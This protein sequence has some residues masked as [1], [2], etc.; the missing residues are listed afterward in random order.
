MTL[1]EIETNE[2][3]NDRTV[4]SSNPTDSHSSSRYSTAT[5]TPY[6]SLERRS[7]RQT[8]TTTT[9]TGAVQSVSAVVRH[10]DDC[11]VTV[12]KPAFVVNSVN[13]LGFGRQLRD[14]ALNSNIVSTEMIEDSESE[15]EWPS[16][17]AEDDD[18]DD[19]Q[20][21]EQ[22]LSSDSLLIGFN[23]VIILVKELS[24]EKLRLNETIRQLK[25]ENQR[26]HFESQTASQ[27]LR[28]FTEWFFSSNQN[29][30]Q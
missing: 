1:N 16:L 28:K 4:E 7:E 18:D 11:V 14:D 23:F 29:Q 15:L 20:L 10:T 26:L 30:N 22:G 3:P 5:S 8:T 6:S 27:Q 12:A 21:K 17:M 25:E 19:C 9:T 24:K 13:E 2:E